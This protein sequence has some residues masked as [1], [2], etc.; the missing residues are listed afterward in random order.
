MR[1]TKE[2]LQVMLDNIDMLESGLCYYVAALSRNS[3]ISYSE[4]DHLIK[5]LDACLPDRKYRGIYIDRLEYCF[6]YGEKEP[7]IEWLKQQIEK[8]K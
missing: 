1:T 4:Y 2:L 3:I 5:Y 6:P 8:L 7:R